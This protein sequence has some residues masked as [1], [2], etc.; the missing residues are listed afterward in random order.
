[1]KTHP[2]ATIIDVPFKCR[3]LRILLR[4]AIEKE[5]YVIISEE[6]IIE[7]IPVIGRIIAEAMLRR[8]LGKLSIGLVHEADVCGI[9]LRGIEGDHPEGLPRGLRNELEGQQQKASD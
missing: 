5:H 1:M 2:G 4:P 9:V 3:T 6:M 8:Y 7:V